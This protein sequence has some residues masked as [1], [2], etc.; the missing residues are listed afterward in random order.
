MCISTVI[1]LRNPAVG[2]TLNLFNC[3]PNY[4][5][6]DYS[7]PSKYPLTIVIWKY[8]EKSCTRAKV[9]K[10]FWKG[11]NRNYFKALQSA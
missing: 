9:S 8:L 3:F 7:H 1:T 5:T 10:L 6:F 2:K 4:L 11:P